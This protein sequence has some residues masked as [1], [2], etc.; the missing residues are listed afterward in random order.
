[1]R[2]LALALIVLTGVLSGET[3]AQTRIRFTLDWVFEGQTSFMHMANYKGYFREEG[4]E[5]QVDVGTGSAGAFQRIVSGVYDAGLGDMSSQIEFLARNPGPLPFQSV[6]VQYDQLPAAFFALKK[7]GIKSV[8]DFAGRTFLESPTGF[9][10]RIWPILAKAADIDPGSVKW[11]TAAPNLRA[12]MLINGDCEIIAGFLSIPIDLERRG[13]KADDIVTMPVADYG[14]HYYGNTLIVSQKLIE[15]NPKAVTGLVRAFNRALKEML[16][17]PAES[18]RYLKQREPIIE[19]P[20]EVRRTRMVMPGMLTQNVRNTGLGA[21]NAERLQK[22]IE[23]VSQA[24]GLANAPSREQLFN[25][26]FL[27]AAAERMVA[28]N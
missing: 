25:P 6:Y 8:K 2:L 13:A 24:Y 19:E 17:N 3:F 11:I 9:S 14:I 21:V 27:P 18:V 5:V 15:G 4:L 20:V 12:N 10:R 28:A 26:R 22:Q 23:Q 7:S 1:M 16:A